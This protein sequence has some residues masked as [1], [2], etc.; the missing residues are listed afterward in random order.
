ME[1][2]RSPERDARDRGAARRGADGGLVRLQGAAGNAAV[3]RAIAG[4]GFGGLVGAGGRG[5]FGGEVAGQRA[6]S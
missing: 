3:A 5:A 4:G 2:E 6:P 1:H